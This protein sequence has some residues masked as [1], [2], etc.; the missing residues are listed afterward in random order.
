MISVDTRT[1]YQTMKELG[2]RKG[3]RG[4]RGE[5]ERGREIYIYTD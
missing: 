2:H 5:T 1:N 4:K 3:E